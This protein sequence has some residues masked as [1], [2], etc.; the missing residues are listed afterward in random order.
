MRLPYGNLPITTTTTS[1][2]HRSR[3]AERVI[4]EGQGR[5]GKE[6]E[7][8]YL[9]VSVYRLIFSLAERSNWSPRNRQETFS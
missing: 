9:R 3:C 4:A 5:E 1:Q 7:D 6:S 8:V 2:L